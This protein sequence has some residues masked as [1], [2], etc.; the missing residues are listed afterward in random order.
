MSILLVCTVHQVGVWSYSPGNDKNIAN[1]L[2]CREWGTIC[3]LFL[4]VISWDHE[5]LVYSVLQGYTRSVSM[6]SKSVHL[7][8][9][10]SDHFLSSY[11]PL[12]FFLS[13]FFFLLIDLLWFIFFIHRTICVSGNQLQKL[14]MQINP[15]CQSLVMPTAFWVLSLGCVLTVR[16]L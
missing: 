2:S 5:L 16:F 8:S 11:K 14:H 15:C 1:L 7:F 10:S 13:L 6:T 12:I 9:F 4:Y 3:N